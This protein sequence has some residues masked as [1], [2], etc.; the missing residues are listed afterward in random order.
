M[1]IKNILLTLFVIFGAALAV[2]SIIQK[3]PQAIVKSSFDPGV[4]VDHVSYTA[5]DQEA[6]VIGQ[7]VVEP[8]ERM[9]LIAQVSG[10]V[11]RVH[12]SLS[13]GGKVSKGTKLVQID[14]TDFSLAINEAK[15]RVKIA[16]QE[17]ALE[18]GRKRAAQKEWELMGARGGAGEV[19]AEARRRA[20]REPQAEIAR[21]NLKIA[22]NALRR[23]MVGYG[24]TTLKAPFN[25]VI[26]SESVDQGQLV[27]PGAPVA[28]LAGTDAF[29]ITTSVPTS[30]L[31]WIDFPKEGEG[32]RRGRRRAKRLGSKAL[33]R[34]DVGAYV[35]EREGHVLRQLTQVET[36]GRMARVIVEVQ[37]PLGLK[38]DAQPLLLGAQVEVE[39]KG[40][41]MQDVIELPRAV[42]REGDALWLF[43]PRGAEKSGESRDLSDPP[44]AQ[45]SYQL[46]SLEVRTVKVLRK[47]KNSVIIKGELSAEDQVIT[48]RIPTPVPGMRLRVRQ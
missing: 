4:L 23:A 17:V 25:A 27:G 26:L 45:G 48:S 31:G 16:E 1:V 46:G 6:R 43:S 28:T 9:S 11:S 41:V 37:D 12:E 20:L 10:V 19:S 22:K 14:P 24:R 34:Y 30:E 2:K 5:N 32:K 38:S 33:I 18:T 40:R 42:L 36:T 7:G 29:W 21:S 15:A 47:R 35:I 39:I 8:A 3:K 13:A 44:N